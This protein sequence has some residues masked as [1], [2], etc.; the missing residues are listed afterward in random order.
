MGFLV[1]LACQAEPV[2]P[3]KTPGFA[4]Q[5]YASNRS[6]GLGTNEMR[7]SHFIKPG[8][9]SSIARLLAA[10][11]KASSAAPARSQT[12]PAQICPVSHYIPPHTQANPKT[13]CYIFNQEVRYSIVGD[14]GREAWNPRL[15]CA[16]SYLQRSAAGY[17]QFGPLP[18]RA[19]NG[20][21]AVR[22]YESG[23]GALL[24]TGL[25]HRVV[26]S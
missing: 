11:L 6:A 19:R 13:L 22:V 10:W 21:F 26:N 5:A 8:T 15:F 18:L 7:P 16:T 23:S 24:K 25:K 3:S 2:D 17:V 14:A 12:P 9:R 1:D 4:Q 20:L